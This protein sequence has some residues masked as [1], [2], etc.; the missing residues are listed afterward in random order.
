MS[1]SFG[2]NEFITSITNILQY[3]SS[4]A[5]SLNK[6]F[7]GIDCYIYYPKG[8]RFNNQYGG[9]HND[10]EY[11]SEYDTKARLLVPDVYETRKTPI[12]GIQDNLYQDEFTLYAEYD[13]YL[14]YGTKIVTTS[15]LLGSYQFRVRDDNTITTPIDAIY[16]EVTLVPLLST[17]DNDSDIDSISEDLLDNWKDQ[18]DDLEAVTDISVSKNKDIPPKGKYNFSKIT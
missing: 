5:I 11:N 4:I 3:T 9:A 15:K 1:D 17:R 6:N 12:A 7:F 2:Q 8:S 16:R 18:V 10:L 13:L 14:P